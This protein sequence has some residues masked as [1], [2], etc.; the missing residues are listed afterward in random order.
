[1]IDGKLLSKFASCFANMSFGPVYPWADLPTGTQVCDVGGGIGT[2]SIELTKKYP[3][4]QVTI[5]DLATTLE[6]AKK[7]SVAT[8]TVC[9]Y[10]HD[11]P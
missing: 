9:A 6:D 3:H 8:D 7:V 5:Q 2:V 11:D 1:M 10:M 4:L